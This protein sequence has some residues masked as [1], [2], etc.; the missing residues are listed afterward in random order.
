MATYLDVEMNR[1][2]T[3]TFRGFLRDENG[4]AVNDPTATYKLTVRSRR[5]ASDPP[6]F[7][8]GGTQFAAGEGRCTIPPSATTSFTRDRVLYYDMQVAETTGTVTTLIKGRL[9]VKMDNAR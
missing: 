8:T 9:T 3:K 4:V 2:D 1:G 6:I 5:D 7:E